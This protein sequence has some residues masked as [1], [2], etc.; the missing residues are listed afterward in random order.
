MHTQ[1]H[2]HTHTHTHE[3]SL[4][5]SLGDSLLLTHRPLPLSPTLAHSPS[6]LFTK[7]RL[8]GRVAMVLRAESCVRVSADP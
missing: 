6:T 8:S 5:P 2:T 7:W 4:L 3:T 1:A